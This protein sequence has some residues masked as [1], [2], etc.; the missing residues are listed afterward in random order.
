M[1]R[2]RYGLN[3]D[4]FYKIINVFQ[5]Y[6]KEIEKVVL[7]GSRAR[8]DYKVTSDIDLAIKF[9]G[10]IDGFHSVWNEL[11]DLHLINTIDLVNYSQISNQ[12][13]KSYIDNE[14]KVIFETNS[15]GEVVIH[16]NKL[17][18]KLTD[19]EKALHK[20]KE[21]ASRDPKIDDIVIDAT[22]QRF[23]FTYELSWKLMKAYLEFQG[24]LEATSPRR[25]I[26]EAFKLNLIQEGNQWLKMLENRNRTSHTYDEDIAWKIFNSIRDE[27]L[28]LFDDFVK[29][30]KKLV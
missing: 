10:D 12:K 4:D 20:L 22:I 26:Q 24:N 6:P 1:K 8:G 14:G 30:L 7:F 5:K 16:V 3:N 25:A 18:D 23:E 28:S 13:L 19:L 27:Y 9:R 21:S 29:R 15:C 2:L 11:E 17:K